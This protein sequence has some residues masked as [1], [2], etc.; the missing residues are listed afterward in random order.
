MTRAHLY[1]LTGVCALPRA[2]ISVPLIQGSY[3]PLREFHSLPLVYF[4]PDDTLL[5][6]LSSAM[7]S[8]Y[9][10]R[11][12]VDSVAIYHC[13]IKIV[14][15][16][17]GKSAVAAAAYRSGETLTNNYD[18][19][20]HDFTRKG[21]IVHTEILLPPH[22]P[23]DFADRSALWNSVEK[24]EKAKNSQ[25]AREIEIALPVELDREKQIQLVR[26]YVK[27]NFVSVGMC[28]DFAIH[29]KQDGNP[30][31]HI[32]LTMRP[33]E[34]S[35]EWGAKSKKEYLLDKGGQRIKLKNGTFKS[36]KVDTVDWNSQEKAEVW[37][38][39]WADT[40]N[41]YLAAQDRPERIDHRSYKRQGI[42]Q[43]PT[44][45]MG[46]AATQMERRGIVTDKGNQNREIREQN[47]LLK[48]VKRRI[49][50]LTAWIKEKTAQT[51]ENP[52]LSVPILSERSEQP[53]TLLELL[54]RAYTE[55]AKPQ[56]RYEKIQDLKLYAK[57]FN[58]L[59]SRNITT[60]VQLQ[61]VVSDMKKQYWTTNGEI[62]Q[63]EKL[64][65]ERKELIDQAEK[66]REHRPT[67]KAYMQ[68]KP[69]KQEDF[70]ESNRVALTLYQ[71]A[72][73][74]L[75]E[76]L[77][78]DKVLKPKAWKA[79]VADLTQKKSRL[80]GSL[81]TLKAEVQEAEA[82]KKCVE[83]AVQPEQ[84]KEKTQNKRRD[85]EL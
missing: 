13:S 65:H 56:S 28:A 39:A 4:T 51:K 43:I 77:G 29:D 75:K 21:G 85:M 42:E 37:R 10:A 5:C 57:A 41:R 45:H 19:V 9:A 64:L 55:A 3:T 14:S 78:E 44:V 7:K 31:A 8:E 46:V 67:Y 16:G 47:R 35:G 20:T 11:K 52:F 84:G 26:E 33:L 80:Y 18:G 2:Y 66:Y 40:A 61:E 15:R 6:S 68:T 69:K 79:E 72:E 32:M 63:T 62:K 73:R 70:F 48:E 25:L 27:E 12:E 23:P 30:H 34:Q 50:A 82:V 49:A 71:S 83:Q 76:H 53:S 58:F 74:Y 24:I 60:L 17:K 81:Q 54:N 59:Q 36:R 22:A 38:Q 1:T